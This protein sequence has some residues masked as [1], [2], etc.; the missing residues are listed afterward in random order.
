MGRG[1][2]VRDPSVGKTSSQLEG[3]S[4]ANSIFSGK[5]QEWARKETLQRYY[6]NVYETVGRDYLTR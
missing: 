3:R 5:P 1:W 2:K 6:F 4:T